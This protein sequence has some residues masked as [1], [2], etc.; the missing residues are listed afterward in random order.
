MGDKMQLTT[1]QRNVG[2]QLVIAAAIAVLSGI[3]I[4]LFDSI[5]QGAVRWSFV[6]LWLLIAIALAG[7]IF[8]FQ[9]NIYWRRLRDQLMKADL[10]RQAPE[11]KYKSLPVWLWLFWALIMMSVARGFGE[12]A[13]LL[14]GGMLAGYGLAAPKLADRVEQLEAGRV[15]FYAIRDADTRR[16]KVVRVLT[17][18]EEE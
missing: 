15:K 1:Q 8:M 6:G 18:D 7:L 4:T 12:V 5:D 3:A 16:P 11:L 9:Q 14:L 10:V 13:V 17:D 2:R